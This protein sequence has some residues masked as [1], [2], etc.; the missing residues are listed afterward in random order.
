MDFASLVGDI[1]RKLMAAG[2]PEPPEVLQKA[3][4]LVLGAHWPH[5]PQK[6]HHHHRMQALAQRWPALADLFTAI[7]HILHTHPATHA[8]GMAIHWPQ[9]AVPHLSL[10]GARAHGGGHHGAVHHAYAPAPAPAHPHPYHP[11][12]APEPVQIIEEEAGPWWGGPW[13]GP[14]LVVVEEPPS[15]EDEQRELEEP[16]PV[17]TTTGRAR[18][19]VA[20]PGRAICEPLGARLNAAWGGIDGYGRQ[21]LTR[22]QRRMDAVRPFGDGEPAWP[23]YWSQRG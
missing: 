17:G 1:T 9:W 7:H 16:P 21:Y 20:Q 2:R 12:R 8:M 15:D 10:T 4:H 14:E 13:W 3:A 6:Q 18:A 22:E 11:H 23:V 5:H 19:V